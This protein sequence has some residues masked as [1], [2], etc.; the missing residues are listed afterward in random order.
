MGSS[1]FSFGIA[2]G[3]SESAKNLLYPRKAEDE[4]QFREAYIKSHGSFAPG[5]QRVRGYEWDKTGMDPTLHRFGKARR[6]RSRTAS[7]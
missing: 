7:S 4:S 5:E 3:S 6:S 1:V 2:T